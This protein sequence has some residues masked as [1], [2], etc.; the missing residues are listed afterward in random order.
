MEMTRKHYCASAAGFSL[1][2]LLVSLAIIGTLVSLLLPAVQ[3]SREAARRTQ[4]A[5][6]LK[7]IGLAIAQHV[8]ATGF[9]PPASTGKN[10][11]PAPAPPDSKPRHSA[12]TYL[13]PYFE[14][15]AAYQALN[16]DYHWNDGEESGDVTDNV[17]YSKQ[18]L[19]GI[20]ICPSAPGGREAKHVSDYIPATNID[21]SSATGLGAL[22]GP[23]RPIQD[24]GPANSDTWLG[25][26]RR[27][28]SASQTVRVTPAHVRDGLSNTWLFFEDG[29]RPLRHELGKFMGTETGSSFRW[30]NWQLTMEI[31]HACQG[32]QLMNCSNASEVYSFH[33]GGCNFLYGDGAVRFH[34]ET[35]AADLFVSLF[36]ARGGETVTIP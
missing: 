21:R 29:G 11:P 36:T 14:Q 8:T 20:L 15:G 30:A 1:V 6:H 25:I 35:I 7:N 18:N 12:I 3:M 32:S 2:E 17:L 31:N 13:L 9:F 4:C 27:D 16:L 26:L 10:N 5:N 22:I 34:V 19:G 33:P 28:P 24:R 23:D